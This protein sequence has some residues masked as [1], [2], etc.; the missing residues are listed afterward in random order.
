M[1]I[2]TIKPITDY[3]YL[4]M[5]DLASK[6]TGVCLWNLKMN[7]PKWTKQLV[8]DDKIEPR[9]KALYDL[10]DDFFIRLKEELGDLSRIFVCK[11]AM[12]AQVGGASTVQTF[13][14]LAKA[15]AVLDLYTSLHDIDVYDYVGIYPVTAHAFYRRLKG[16][17]HTEKVTKSH[18]GN[19]VYNHF[20][21]FCSSQDESDA[22]FLAYTLVET[23]WDNDIYDAQKQL[24]KH[25]RGLVK[26]AAKSKIKEEIAALDLL[27]TKYIKEEKNQ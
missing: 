15:H 23:K 20:S 3:D 11:E 5:F 2:K 1:E 9:T 24:R 18:I 27:K 12:P 8:V 4:V 13:L 14:A 21:L 25:A 6:N 17:G 10:L 16:L 26:D 19:Y 22:V 7:Y